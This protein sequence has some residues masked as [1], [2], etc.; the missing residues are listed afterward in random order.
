M[1]MLLILL[2]NAAWHLLT[3][4]CVL[5]TNTFGFVCAR[6]C[7]CSI[8]IA[9]LYLIFY[10]CLSFTIENITVNCQLRIILTFLFH[11]HVFSLLFFYLFM[12]FSSM[13]SC[14]RVCVGESKYFPIDFMPFECILT[15]FIRSCE[16][17]VTLQL[18]VYAPALVH[19]YI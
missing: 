3:N 1:V 6:V 2:T 7:V 11:L 9:F 17:V 8:A 14:M 13:H 5:P 18:H 15:V 12:F 10:C 16:Q 4:N 19:M